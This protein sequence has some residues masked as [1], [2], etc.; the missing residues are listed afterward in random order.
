MA[1]WWEAHLGFMEQRR[2][3]EI[4]LIKWPHVHF[5]LH[6][7]QLSSVVLPSVPEKDNLCLPGWARPRGEPFLGQHPAPDESV[8]ARRAA[9]SHAMQHRA[10]P[11]GLQRLSELSL[12]LPT[13]LHTLC[14]AKGPGRRDTGGTEIQPVLRAQSAQNKGCLLLVGPS[15]GVNL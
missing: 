13:P 9:R 6:P 15:T 10:G 11:S 8:V 12:G 5:F 14:A 3:D 2:G 1:L 4:L 7:C